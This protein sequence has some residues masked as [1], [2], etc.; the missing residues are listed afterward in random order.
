M[1]ILV[2]DDD[3]DT[4]DLQDLFTAR[5]TVAGRVV[6]GDEEA[7]RKMVRGRLTQAGFELDFVVDGDE[8]LARF[9]Q[10]GPYDLVLTDL[11]H[12][13]LDGISLAWAVRRENPTQ[14]IAVFTVCGPD[15]C[16]EACWKLS[17]PVGYKLD[18]WQA[19]SRLV[20][21]ASVMNRERLSKG[22]LGKIQ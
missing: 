8:A 16:L 18:E 21:D 11:Y 20:K 19:L 17:I 9:R 2:V 13:G 3:L 6:N 7:W 10:K 14:A 15:S 4:K 5:L 22:N 12:P 1:K